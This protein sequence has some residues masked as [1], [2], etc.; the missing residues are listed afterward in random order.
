MKTVLEKA[1]K[2]RPLLS[3]RP[4]KGGQLEVSIVRMGDMHLAHERI[5]A[6]IDTVQQLFNRKKEKYP[7][8]SQMSPDMNEPFLR[9]VP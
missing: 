7:I 5:K 9:H 3:R 2:K 8:S 6:K 1:R 4:K